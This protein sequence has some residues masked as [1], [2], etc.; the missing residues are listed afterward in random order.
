MNFEKLKNIV[1]QTQKGKFF[2]KPLDKYVIYATLQ[3]RTL[4]KGACRIS[5]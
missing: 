4:G 1:Q 5:L 3:K 2:S